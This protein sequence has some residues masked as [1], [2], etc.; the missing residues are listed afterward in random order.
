MHKW[1]NVTYDCGVAFTAH[2]GSHS[3]AFTARA[4]YLVFDST[5][6]DEID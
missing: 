6:R 5:T 2:P 1:L 4:P 3:A